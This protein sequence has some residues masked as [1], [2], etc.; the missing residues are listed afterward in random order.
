MLPTVPTNNPDRVPPTSTIETMYCRNAPPPTGFELLT[1]DQFDRCLKRFEKAMVTSKGHVFKGSS[2][3][4]RYEDWINAVDEL[5]QE[6]GLLQEEKLSAIQSLRLVA[7]LART[8]LDREDKLVN[9]RWR[10]VKEDV[11][12]MKEFK[13]TF[14]ERFLGRD[15]LKGLWERA[16]P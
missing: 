7:V 16:S 3:V 14:G 15:P 8:C 4:Q 10:V 1:E 13:S 6:A 5:L 12:T 11:R 9:E 2:D